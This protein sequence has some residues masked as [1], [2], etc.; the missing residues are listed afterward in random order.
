VFGEG[1]EPVATY[2]ARRLVGGVVTLF[3]AGLV[4][5]S[6]MSILPGGI[7][8]HITTIIDCWDCTPSHWEMFRKEEEQRDRV[9]EADK[10]WPINYIAWMFNPDDVT[11]IQTVYENGVFEGMRDVPK[12]I[13]ITL[14]G[15]HIRGSGVLTGDFA[16]STDVYRG[17]KVTDIFGSGLGE[18]ML[19]AMLTL[20]VSMG[21]VVVRRRVRPC[22][23]ALPYSSRQP[24]TRRVSY[25]TSATNELFRVQFGGV[26]SI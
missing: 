4:L 13:S 21:V 1:G 12:G 17:E 24:V 19:L 3:L 22:M 18:F 20:V 2:F 7:R 16:N 23:D 14:L 11:T 15:L 6:L 5:Y 8:D 9:W 26:Y 25:R 10:P